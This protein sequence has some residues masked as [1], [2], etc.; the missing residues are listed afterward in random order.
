MRLV[1]PL[2]MLLFTGVTGLRN[3]WRE[4]HVA[5]TGAQRFTSATEMAFGAVSWPAL[6]A[7]LLKRSHARVLLF[8]WAAL[9]TLTGTVAA[10]AW[11]GA[12]LGAAAVG[13]VCVAAVCG[14]TVWLAESWRLGPRSRRGDAE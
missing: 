8:A 4:Y 6:A 5:T 13:G 3:G 11:G 12:G 7:L 1:L 9:V 10:V 2:L 14:L